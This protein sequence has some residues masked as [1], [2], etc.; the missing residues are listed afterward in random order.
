MADVIFVF[1]RR[2]LRDISLAFPEVRSRIVRLG[3]FLPG[4]EVEIADP[5]GQSPERFEDCYRRIA[6][7]LS[8]ISR[9]CWAPIN[10]PT[11]DPQSFCGKGD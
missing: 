5:F 1:D 10:I 9:M 4:S 6:T 3:D 7:S 2:N 8:T 11:A